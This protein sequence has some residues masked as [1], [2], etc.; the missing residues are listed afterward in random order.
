[1]ALF[2]Y[3]EKHIGFVDTRLGH[4]DDGSPVLT[5]YAFT[6]C[7][8]RA[9]RNG[10]IGQARS[11]GQGRPPVLAQTD[12]PSLSIRR[13][14]QRTSDRLR[15]RLASV[16][17][18]GRIQTLGATGETDPRGVVPFAVLNLALDF[19]SIAG[20]I[21]HISASRCIPSALCGVRTSPGHLS[22]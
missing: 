11:V 21:T 14:F 4:F 9:S 10:A 6:A 19:A 1:M 5:T 2:G 7:A 3:Q 15:T 8:L 12:L 16:W 17:R 18:F 13:E 20:D 22:R